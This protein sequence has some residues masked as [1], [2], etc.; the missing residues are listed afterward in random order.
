MNVIKQV[1]CV[2]KDATRCIYGHT[3]VQLIATLSQQLFFNNYA[4]PLQLEP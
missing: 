3:L 4:I 1:A 2:A